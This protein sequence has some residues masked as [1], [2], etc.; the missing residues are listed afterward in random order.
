MKRFHGKEVAKLMENDNDCNN[1]EPN[2][3]SAQIIAKKIVPDQKIQ[4]KT[5]DR[6]NPDISLFIFQHRL[7]WVSK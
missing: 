1:N 5:C 3:A 2:P 6:P 4:G 7:G